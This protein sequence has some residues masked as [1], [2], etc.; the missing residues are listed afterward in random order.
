MNKINLVTTIA[1]VG[2]VVLA[3]F[4]VV[5]NARQTVALEQL[6][7]APS[8]QQKGPQTVPVI[9]GNGFGTNSAF[10]GMGDGSGTSVKGRTTQLMMP[11]RFKPGFVVHKQ[12]PDAGTIGTDAAYLHKYD[13]AGQST[14]ARMTSLDQE[15][16]Q[17]GEKARS[18]YQKAGLMSK[19][20]A[21]WASSMA[22]GGEKAPVQML[23]ELACGKG[24]ACP[25]LAKELKQSGITSSAERKWVA[26]MPVEGFKAPFQQL[27]EVS[28]KRGGAARTVGRDVA[29][30]L[31]GGKHG[32]GL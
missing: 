1:V 17:Y 8:T 13:G 28:S 31:F 19:Q 23:S 12:L 25:E 4:Q 11:D 29:G 32:V 22:T 5:G 7:K 18:F 15:Y 2:C 30:Y 16:K 21:R 14:K 9:T 26:K 20:E 3:T 27:K 6:A 10:I 24:G